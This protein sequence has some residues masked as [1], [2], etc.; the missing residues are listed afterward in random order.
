MIMWWMQKPSPTAL[1]LATS[2]TVMSIHAGSISYTGVE[3]GDDVSASAQIDNRVESTAG[4]LVAD[5]YTQSLDADGH[6]VW[7]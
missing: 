3:V 7:M 1:P 6:A 5:T 2:L 4:F